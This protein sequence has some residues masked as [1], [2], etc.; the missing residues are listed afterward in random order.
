[1]SEQLLLTTA[2][3]FAFLSVALATVWAGAQLNRRA[4]AR[5]RLDL[6][7]GRA[8]VGLASTAFLP[9]GMKE[10][11]ENGQFGAD[12]TE[13]SRQRMELIRAGF[14][15]QDAVFGFLVA[16]IALVI[17]LPVVMYLLVISRFGHWG[18]PMKFGAL[19]GCLL[20]AYY[21]PEAYVRRRQ[22]ALRLMYRNAFPDFL[23]L[24]MVCV[25]AG[26]SLEAALE[27]LA[28]ARSVALPEMRTNLAI[29]TAEMRAGRS[30][31]EALHGFGE[32]IGLPEAQAFCVLLKQSLELGSDVSQALR[33][34]SDEM[35][36]KR[37]SRAEET[38]MALPVK[39]TLPL[40]AFIFPCILIIVLTPVGIR[41]SSMFKAM[42]H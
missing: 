32:R 20:L 28:G 38:A 35:R 11:I 2:I 37:M 31:I 41:I 4:S 3:A 16:R 18:L 23:D 39:L 26:L 14:F 1:M 12:A 13:R 34:Y 24:L 17:F 6:V 21:M 5:Q 10:R 22:D 27:R 42:V 7:E 33:T 36:E 19:A 29:A 30:T 15:S 40:G 8:A 9:R 25:D